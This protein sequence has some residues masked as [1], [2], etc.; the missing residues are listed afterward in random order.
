MHNNF[1][2]NSRPSYVDELFKKYDYE[3]LDPWKKVQNRT[4]NKVVCLSVIKEVYNKICN[5]VNS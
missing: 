4:K 3:A 2:N 1:N 5:W